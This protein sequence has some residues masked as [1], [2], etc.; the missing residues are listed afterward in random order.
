MLLVINFNKR[1]LWFVLLSALKTTGHHARNKF[2]TTFVKKEHAYVA[3]S[4]E[5]IRQNTTKQKIYENL[6]ILIV[7]KLD[8]I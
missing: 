6:L 1:Y 8:F 7:M 3:K 5:F 2:Y 4:K